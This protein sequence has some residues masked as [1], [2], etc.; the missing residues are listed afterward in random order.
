MS[1]EPD[2]TTGW[3]AGVRRAAD[4][5]WG[6]VRCRLELFA[7]ELQEEKERFLRLVVWLATIA[8][9]GAAGLLL[10]LGLTAWMLYQWIGPWGPAGLGFL[11]LAAAALGLRRILQDL[12]EGPAPFHQTVAEFKKDR[13]WLS[14]T[15]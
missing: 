7:L 6:L 3:R 9:L 13:Q 2:A 4:A 15:E 11:S 12:R 14:R 10:L 1:P 8:A 5:L